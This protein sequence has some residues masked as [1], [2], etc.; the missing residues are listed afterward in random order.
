MGID[1]IGPSHR[2]GPS[3]LLYTFEGGPKR[4]QETE[5]SVNERVRPH[6]GGFS[7]EILS[8]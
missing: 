5:R 6:R 7:S 2:E 3:R 4:L 8:G 1:A